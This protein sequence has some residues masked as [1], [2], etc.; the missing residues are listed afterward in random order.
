M[1]TGSRQAGIVAALSVVTAI[2]LGIWIGSYE[3]PP[4]PAPRPDAASAADAP[5]DP[6]AP[7]SPK[8]GQP[9]K[10]V[11]W[12]PTSGRL[13]N[14]MLD[15]ARV[16][17]DDY[18]IDL[19]SGDGRTVIAAAKRGARAVGIEFNGA[20]VALARNDARLQGVDQRVRFIEGDLFK[21]DLSRATV[22]TMFLLPRINLQLRP[23][24]LD[25]RPGTRVVSNSFDMGDWPPDAEITVKDDECRSWCTA[26]LW[27]V[28]AK[29]AA[30]W[31]TPDGP[32]V[33]TQKF[34]HVTGTL[35]GVPISSG[36]LTGRRLSF[37][38]N[39]QQYGAEVEGDSLTAVAG[40]SWVARR[41]QPAAP[42]SR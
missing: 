13:V 1:Q 22:I 28:P 14:A 27:I 18:V 20:M 16:T 34:Q 42:A 2:G 40:A 29:V 17:A 35:A 31:D 41:I 37:I 24:L 10:D 7:F 30:T 4:P 23:T 32:L 25:L 38:V 9:G 12:V 8:I 6:N 5:P 26:L 36:R 11:V 21:T 19:G 39:G 3:P 15:L 33:L